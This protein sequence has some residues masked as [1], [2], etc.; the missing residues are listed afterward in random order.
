LDTCEAI[1]NFI[2][3]IVQ[4]RWIKLLVDY[5]AGNIDLPSSIHLK[6]GRYWNEIAHFSLNEDPNLLQLMSVIYQEG[7]WR[8]N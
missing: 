6:T 2:N 5:L 8:N 1:I 7:M 3:N 4:F